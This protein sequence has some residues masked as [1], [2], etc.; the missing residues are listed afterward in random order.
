[1][2]GTMSILS[3]ITKHFFFGTLQ[4]LLK[5]GKPP[6]LVMN[7]MFSSLHSGVRTDH[8]DAALTY[9]LTV[10]EHEPNWLLNLEDRVVG[11]VSGGATVGGCG[12][13]QG[14]CNPLGGI[15]CK[16]QF[17]KY[18]VDKD[19][20]ENVIGKTSYR[21]FLAVKGMQAK[22]RMLK[23]K[24]TSDTM[25]AGFLIPSM[26]KDFE[27]NEDQTSDIMK[28]LAA[29]IGFGGALGGNMPVAVSR[30]SRL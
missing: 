5:F 8:S 16:E 22:F 24:L 7:S 12:S 29:A 14:S 9:R 21:I 17:N 19:G 10:A 2:F 15:D 1:M 25:V 3:V 27:G 23:D 11:G 6:A 13:V 20:N 18:G 30:L 4:A 26:V 28:W